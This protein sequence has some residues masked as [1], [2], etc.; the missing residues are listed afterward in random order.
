MHD[1]TDTILPADQL[2]Q[3]R[4]LL[5]A[6]SREAGNRGADELVDLVGRADELAADLLRRATV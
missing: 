1:L 6:I 5:A 3:I 2:R 4:A